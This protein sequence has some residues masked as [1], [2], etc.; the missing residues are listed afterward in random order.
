MAV[1]GMAQIIDMI[2]AGR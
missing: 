2:C 1:T